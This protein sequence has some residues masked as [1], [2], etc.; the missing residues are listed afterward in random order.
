MS[1]HTSYSLPHIRL[2]WTVLYMVEFP[3]YVSWSLA[4]FVEY[5]TTY[6]AIYNT[7]WKIM[8]QMG[9]SSCRPIYPGELGRVH[10]QNV[11]VTK[12]SVE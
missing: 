10:L 6:Y 3:A 4:R 9:I 12:Q 8:G 7:L 2:Y 5:W 11:T 1:N